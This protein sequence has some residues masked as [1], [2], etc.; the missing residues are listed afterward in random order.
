MIASLRSGGTK[1]SPEANLTLHPH[2]CKEHRQA[3]KVIEVDKSFV[4]SPVGRKIPNKITGGNGKLQ[5][6][7]EFCWPKFILSLKKCTNNCI[8]TNSIFEPDMFFRPPTKGNFTALAALNLRF[9]RKK[10]CRSTHF[11]PTNTL[12]DLQTFQHLRIYSGLATKHTTFLV[13][14]QSCGKR[15]VHIEGDFV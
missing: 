1:Y 15:T 6:V 12:W 2:C 4:Y 8:R 13:G 10:S 5:K 11:A 14:G 9:S 7:Q 3:V